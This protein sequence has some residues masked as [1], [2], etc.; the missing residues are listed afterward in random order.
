MSMQL[1]GQV[2]MIFT[3]SLFYTIIEKPRE[4]KKHLINN[5]EAQAP[6]PKN[7][8]HLNPILGSKDILRVLSLKYYKL[9]KPTVT[10]SSRAPAFL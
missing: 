7:R 4:G 6:P 1:L 10:K 8:N 3:S 9:H 5:G 2:I